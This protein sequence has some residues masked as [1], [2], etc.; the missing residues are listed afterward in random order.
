[1]HFLRPGRPKRSA[2]CLAAAASAWLASWACAHGESE[3]VNLRGAAL[4]LDAA[5]VQVRYEGVP[6]ARQRQ[7][8][9]LEPALHTVVRQVLQAGRVRHQT[10]G[11]CRQH[12]AYT[13]VVVEVRYLDPKNYVGFGDPAYAYVLNLHV[14]LPNVLPVVGGGTATNLYFASS[15]NDIHSEKRTGKSVESALTALGRVQAGDLVRAWLQANPRSQAR[16]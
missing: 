16:P 4:C 7:A 2:F 15:W 12:P 3:Q 1:M 5:S 13:R 9:G 10:R 11:S 8:S 14:G 6:P